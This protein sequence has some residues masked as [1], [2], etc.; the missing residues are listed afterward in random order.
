MCRRGNEWRRGLTRKLP[1]FLLWQIRF[2]GLIG[3]YSIMNEV[4][5]FLLKTILLWHSGIGDALCAR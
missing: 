4:H 5:I 2:E 1:G 3:Y